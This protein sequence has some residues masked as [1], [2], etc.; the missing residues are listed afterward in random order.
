MRTLVLRWL[1]KSALLMFLVSAFTFVLVSFTPGDPARSILGPTGTQEQYEAL[2]AQMG[3]NDSLVARYFDWLGGAVQGDLGSSLFSGESVTTLLAERL[4]VTLTLVFGGVVLSA[5][6]GV[7]LGVLS[8]RRTGWLARLVDVV[9][10]V[11]SAIPPFWL[12]LVLSAIFA[13]QLRLLPAVGYTPIAESP[14]KW[15]ESITLPVVTLALAGMAL[16]AKQTRDAMLQELDK[17]YVLMLRAQGAS[18]VSVQLRHALR[19]AAVPIVTVLGV[20]LIGLLGGTVLVETVFSLPGLGGL[21][22]NSTLSHDLP[23][24]QGV[25]VLFALLVVTIN[26]FVD[27][28]YAWVNPKVRA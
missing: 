19:N 10:L 3:L 15:L 6:L 2:R 24:V 21:A 22:V 7:G 12:G 14:V 25:A 9:S 4:G 5:L 23:V 17:E 28:T 18:E 8:A 1:V 26:L 27:L 16:V 20:L 11:G 13:V